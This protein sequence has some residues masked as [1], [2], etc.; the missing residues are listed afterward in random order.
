[1]RLGWSLAL[2]GCILFANQKVGIVTRSP[3]RMA[4]SW[5]QR[6]T[7][8]QL[9]EVSASGKAGR[10]P[11]DRAQPGVDQ[12]RVRAAVAAALQ[13]REVLG[14]LDGPWCVNRWIGLGQHA[15][16]SRAPSPAGG[17]RARKRRLR[18]ALGVDHRLLVLD[19]LP[20]E[21]L[22][23]AVGV[24]ALAILASGVEQAAGHL[25]ARRRCP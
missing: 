15:W 14:V 21:G 24:K 19:L 18:S 25:G 9:A 7:M 6:P 8:V 10:S 5:A 22:L 23:A 4:E 12:V 20:L 2:R 17:S 13:E 11:L 16:R 3:P 1:M